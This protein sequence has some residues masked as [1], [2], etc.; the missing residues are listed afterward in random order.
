MS[1]LPDLSRLRKWQAEAITLYMEKVRKDFTV[2]A[3]PGAGKTTFALTLAKHLLDTKIVDRVIVVVPTD[4][5]RTQ[6]GQAAHKMGVLLD[7]TLGNN[8]LLKKGFNGYVTTYAQVA[9]HPL[10]HERRTESPNRTFVIFDEIHHAGDGL[11]W[12]TAITEAFT[13]ATRRLALTGTPFRT[14]PMERIPFVEYE[15]DG[16]EIKS[17]AD[18]TYGYQQAL[19]N[20][21]V[22]PVLFAAYTGVARWSNNAGEI[23]A[24]LTDELT[25]DEEFAAWKTILDPRGEWVPHVLASAAARLDEVRASGMHDAGMLV[26]ASD[27]ETAKAYAKV[28]ETVTGVKP[29]LVLSEDSK[30]SEKIDAFAR[31][32]DKYLV[33]V[34]M[35]SEGVDIPRCAVLVWLTSYRTP[36]FFAQAVGRVVRSRREGEA[37][38]VFLPAVRP[39][40]ALASEIEVARN[41][42]L[43]PAKVSDDEGMLDVIMPEREASEPVEEFKALASHAEFAHVLFSG[44]AITAMPEAQKLDAEDEEHLGLFG[45]DPSLLSPE[46]MA[47][48]L[49]GR[50][51]SLR[52]KSAVVAK[53]AD[54]EELQQEQAA[55]HEKLASIRK[56]ISLL[57]N[58]F[59]TRTGKPHSEIHIIV[60]RMVPG[61]A[62][63]EADLNLLMRRRDWLLSR[64]H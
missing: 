9:A 28:L 3:T 59:A 12:G 34:R 54:S 42:V 35:V 14:S 64:L 47:S 57:V 37:A 8:A 51:K 41:H 4:H 49:A 13:N 31:G 20:S 55:L 2:T 46:L 53:A 32:L 45:S 24:S 6:W 43:A 19:E 23:A 61:P 48:M 1:S 44:K 27:Q 5:L 29:T 17:I 16:D 62:T 39:L 18:Y 56:E 40:L 36:L 26:L 11:S 21:V 38:T 50:D 58:R 33:A 15:T 52:V 25:K 63:S 22:R 7:S 30:A 60:R 10:L